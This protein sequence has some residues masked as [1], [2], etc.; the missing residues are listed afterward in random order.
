MG[1]GKLTPL[2]IFHRAVPEDEASVREK[3]EEVEKI[4]SGSQRKRK[5]REGIIVKGLDDILV[6]FSK[7]C[8]PLPGDPIIGYIT[9]GQGVTNHRKNCINVMKMS[10]E[11]QIEVQWSEDD[12]ETYPAKIRVRSD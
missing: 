12:Q 10:P 3:S 4:L 11:R 1:F 7:C 6:R 8:N 5:T 9:Q 2:Q